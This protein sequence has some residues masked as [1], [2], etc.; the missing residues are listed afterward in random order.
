MAEH[1]RYCSLCFSSSLLLF[2]VLLLLVIVVYHC[3]FFPFR[4]R[5]CW[6]WALLIE[7][8]VSGIPFKTIGKN[9][10][11]VRMYSLAIDTNMIH[12]WNILAFLKYIYVLY[13][14]T[15]FCVRFPPQ[16]FTDGHAIN[17]HFASFHFLAVYLVG[18]VL[19]HIRLA[20]KRA[21]PYIPVHRL[22]FPCSVLVSCI[23]GAVGGT[24]YNVYCLCVCVYVPMLMYANV[25]G[26]F[27]M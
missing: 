25:C 22:V 3:V 27:N 24:I 11:C 26:D 1:F 17:F 13:A 8:A 18:I 16:N 10:Y 12:T 19:F 20:I 14:H 7:G 9:K 6:E 23:Y 4:S 5:T 15:R 21:A 2:V